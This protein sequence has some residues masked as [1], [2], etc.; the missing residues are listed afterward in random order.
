MKY[1]PVGWF[2][3]GFR[4]V[5]RERSHRENVPALS[6]ASDLLLSC[7]KRSNFGISKFSPSRRSRENLQGAIF[8]IAI[9]QLEPK[10]KHFIQ[11]FHR[12]LDM[13]DCTFY[14]PNS[15]ALDIRAVFNGN[16]SILM[17]S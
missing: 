2:A 17:P 13:G 1:A 11:H 4:G 6:L 5:N 16:N 3:G 15:E 8:R 12:C 14:R 9:V 10:R 7:R